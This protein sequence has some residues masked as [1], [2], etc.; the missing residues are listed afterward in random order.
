MGGFLMT[1]LI[2]A[3]VAMLALMVAGIFG[4]HIAGAHLAL[5]GVIA[6]V[7]SGLYSIRY[8]PHY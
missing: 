1:G 4:V 5:S 7:M 3:V 2:I 8:Q 6:L